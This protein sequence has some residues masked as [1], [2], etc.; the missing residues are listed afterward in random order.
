[1]AGKSPQEEAQEK[2]YNEVSGLGTD[3]SKVKNRFDNY[4]DLFN[5]EDISGQLNKIF[6][7]GENK[8][9]R[10]TSDLIAE[11]Q[12]GAGRS[13]ASRGITGGSV[14]TDTESKIASDVNKTKSNALSDLKIGEATSLGDLMKYF[15]QEKMKKTQLATD[16]DLSNIRNLFSKFGLEGSAISGLSDDTALDDWLSVFNTAGGLAKGVGSIITGGG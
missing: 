2:F 7:E 5:F 16:V 3:A 8:I 14:L 9:N 11:T 4:S 12:A 13:L 1:M 6:G 10:S 15:N